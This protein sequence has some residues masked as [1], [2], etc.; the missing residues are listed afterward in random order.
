MDE[1]GKYFL[2][3]SSLVSEAGMLGLFTSI[4]NVLH[5]ACGYLECEVKTHPAAP[6]L[7]L[8]TGAVETTVK[9]P[10]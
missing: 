8:L 4:Q 10:I 7:I 9:F 2:S 5:P 3:N 1:Q 6:P